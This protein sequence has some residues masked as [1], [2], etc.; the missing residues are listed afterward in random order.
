[1]LTR[2][3]LALAAVLIGTTAVAAALAPTPM[4]DGV[5]SAPE[6]RRTPPAALGPRAAGGRPNH[7][8]TANFTDRPSGRGVVARARVGDLVRLVIS[9]RR[10]GVVEVGELAVEAVDPSV[11]TTIELLADR[12]GTFDVVL[13]DERRV[14]GRL[15]VAPVR[16]LSGGA[17][18]RE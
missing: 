5:R 13:S 4:R 9:T 18:R 2:R 1:M 11:P 15:E 8:I 10:A 16:V 6:G 3:L 14:L 17:G 12:P 7:T